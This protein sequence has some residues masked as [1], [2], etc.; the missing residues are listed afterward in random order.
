MR[1][2]LKVLFAAALAALSTVAA[3]A[4]GV[5]LVPSSPQYNEPSQI[6]STLNA[7]INQLNGNPSGSGGYAAQ[8]GGIVSLGSYCTASG[9]TPQTC[10]ATRGLVTTASLS[11]AAATNANYVINNSL[12]SATSVCQV[13]VA[14]YSGTLVTNGYPQPLVVTTGTGTI[15]VS[16]TNTHAANALSGTV[17]LAFNCIN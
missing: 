6:V 2:A 14:S 10:N 13:T 15:T 11:T 12:V 8:P 3:L 17:G 16:L 9:A 7:F 5:P 4:G 1:V